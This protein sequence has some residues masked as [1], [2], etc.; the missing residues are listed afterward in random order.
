M[1]KIIST[2][3]IKDGLVTKNGAFSLV[4]EGKTIYSKHINGD[5]EWLNYDI[6]ESE[7]NSL[8]GFGAIVYGKK[9]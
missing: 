5:W 7:K 4:V 8:K 6:L 3:N 9:I 2:Q 1:K